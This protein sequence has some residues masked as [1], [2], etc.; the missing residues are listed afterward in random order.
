MSWKPFSAKDTWVISHLAECAL[1]VPQFILESFSS[2]PPFGFPPDFSRK[3]NGLFDGARKIAY[4]DYGDRYRRRRERISDA[5]IIGNRESFGK[6]NNCPMASSSC[7]GP[8]AD[9]GAGERAAGG[10]GGRDGDAGVQDQA[11]RPRAAGHLEEK[12]ETERYLMD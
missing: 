9:P 6:E 8:R 10:A 5:M 4:D 7:S 12:G 2:P 1:R 3:R 11:G